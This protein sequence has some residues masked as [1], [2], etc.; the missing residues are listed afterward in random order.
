MDISLKLQKSDYADGF[1]QL[2]T[3]ISFTLSTIS[4]DADV[5][6]L[7]ESEAIL[8]AR[9]SLDQMSIAPLEF[10][11]LRMVSTM[12]AETLEAIK[13]F[14]DVW[15]SVLGK[16]ELFASI[17]D[18]AS[19]IIIA[20]QH[21]DGSIFQWMETIDDVHSFLSEAEP[22]KTISTHRE[23]LEDLSSLTVE[24]AYLIRDYTVDK[25]FWTRIT[26]MTLVGVESKIQQYNEK[27]KEI[28][29]RFNERAIVRIDIMLLRCL[30]EIQSIQGMASATFPLLDFGVAE[31]DYELN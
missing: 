15:G 16:L 25:S 8:Q 24:C 26:N 17:L 4:Q 30:E 14:E 12:S 21:R 5:V 13:S 7:R 11:K 23:I 19:E 18:R 29:A 22:L 20:Q 2:P 27:F 6:G 1:E 9:G 28:K 31:L 10:G 3:V